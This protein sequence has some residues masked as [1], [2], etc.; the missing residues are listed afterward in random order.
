MRKLLFFIPLA[1]FLG[2]AVFLFSGLFSNPRD[3]GSAL[4]AQPMPKFSLP[5]LTEPS[6]SMTNADLNGKVYLLNVWGTWC[7]TCNAELGFLTTLRQQGVDIIGLY[8]VQPAEAA[9]GEK[10]EMSTLQ[11]EV[12]KKLAEQGDPYQFNM[13]DEKRSLIFDLGVTGAP[14]T[15]LVDAQGIIRHH[16]VGDINPQNW[17]ALQAKYQALVAQT[18]SDKQVSAPKSSGGQ[19]E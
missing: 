17:P 16:L 2:L 7:V 13:V 14:E 18:P 12:A 6:R 10:F 3:H 5:N 1:L 15:F 8:Y 4:V 19:S 9:F 11:K